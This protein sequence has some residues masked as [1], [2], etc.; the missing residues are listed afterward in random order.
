MRFLD[1]IKVVSLAANLP[2]PAAARRFY[3]L[4]AQ[5][6]KIEPPTGD[7]MARY[8]AEWYRE[9]NS[10]QEILTLNLKSTADKTRL[11]SE[12]QKADILITANRLAALE[13]LGL[14]WERLNSAFPQL[15]QVAIVGYPPPLENEPGHDL[16]YQAKLGL[17]T[18][19]TM[20]RLLLADMIG[21]EKA[22]SE[23]L[24]LLFAREKGRGGGY[25]EVS[26]SEAAEY[27][28]EP[29]KVGLTAPGA[30]FGGQLPEYNLY[31]TGDGW[32]AVAALEP[33]FKKALGE[34]LNVAI[35]SEELRL[36][37]KTKTS[38]EWGVWA[39][40]RELPIVEVK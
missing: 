16:T 14:G 21:A 32:I 33:H 8:S 6:L 25:R 18:P 27:M 2:G 28:G 12:L 19:P 15:C 40:E 3:Q 5:V 4:G 38:R 30:V 35:Q 7:P 36:V 22:V 9:L 31:E 34:A 13:R 10:G 39:K 24:A 17:L 29:W 26:L 1:G 37:F 11:D 23:A 20:P